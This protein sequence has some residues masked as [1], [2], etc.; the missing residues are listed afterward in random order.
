M[1]LS[2]I[3]RQDV[4]LHEWK[5]VGGEEHVLGSAQADALRTQAACLVGVRS[6]IGISSNVERSP[7]FIGP[8]EKCVEFFW[9]LRSS[10]PDSAEEDL[11]SPA[12]DGYLGPIGNG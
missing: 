3:I 10:C 12:V 4:S 11:P 9:R 6:S 7:K 5:P 8:L 1:L 2:R